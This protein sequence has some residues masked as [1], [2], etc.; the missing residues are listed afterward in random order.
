LLPVDLAVSPHPENDNP[1]GRAANR[2][3]DMAKGSKCVSIVVV[4]EE[5][6][7]PSCQS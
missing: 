6:V 2:F 7:L 3:A 1:T 5:Q 4:Y